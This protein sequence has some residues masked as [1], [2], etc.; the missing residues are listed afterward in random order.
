M[1][2][3]ILTSL[4]TGSFFYCCKIGQIPTN[5][6]NITLIDSIT[7][8]NHQIDK[9][10][11]IY[12]D[13]QYFID[14]EKI[15]IFSK[16]LK[17]G[18]I[19]DLNF[20]SVLSHILNLQIL[21]DS[22]IY[23]DGIPNFIVFNLQRND[24]IVYPKNMD[25]TSNPIVSNENIYIAGINFDSETPLFSINVIDYCDGRFEPVAIK[26]IEPENK[27]ENYLLTG[28]L[29]QNNN[30]LFFI[31]DWLGEYYIIDKSNE[32]TIKHDLLPLLGDEKQFIGN[33]GSPPYY[34]AYSASMYGTI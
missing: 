32:D 23:I 26:N 17:N 20:S 1:K 28:H 21:N 25:M 13:H 3:I 4:I 12:R 33:A 19:K 9:L 14:K 6:V 34:Q 24:Y 11:E 18:I 29:L 5:E 8:L 30:R 7:I 2:Q 31:F 16:N 22:L 27:V 10:P 15:Q